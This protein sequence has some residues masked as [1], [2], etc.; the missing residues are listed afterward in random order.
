MACARSLS[1][2]TPAR[3]LKLRAERQVEHHSLCRNYS[4]GYAPIPCSARDRLALGDPSLSHCAV[5]KSAIG[6]RWRRRTKQQRKDNIMKYLFVLI[7]SATLFVAYAQAQTTTSSTSTT[8][9]ATPAT[10][11]QTSG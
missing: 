5:E 9:D 4:F 11:S 7:C 6:R 10:T 1:H 2:L 3:R 8:S